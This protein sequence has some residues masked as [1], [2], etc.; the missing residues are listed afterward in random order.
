MSIQ[1]TTNNQGNNQIIFLSISGKG[2]LPKL[3]TIIANVIYP[4]KMSRKTVNNSSFIFFTKNGKEGV[5]QID[6]YD[7]IALYM[8]KK[9]DDKTIEFWAKAIDDKLN[10]NLPS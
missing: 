7:C 5:I 3:F 6:E 4:E 9:N 10:H 8:E 2:W 1:K